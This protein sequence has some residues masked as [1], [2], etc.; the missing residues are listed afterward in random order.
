MS[1]ERRSPRGFSSRSPKRGVSKRFVFGGFMPR[2]PAH[3]PPT[4]RL[5]RLRKRHLGARAATAR[6]LEGLLDGIHESCEL[7]GVKTPGAPQTPLTVLDAAIAFSPP[8]SSGRALGRIEEGAVASGSEGAVPHSASPEGGQAAPQGGLR[9][10][11]VW[12]HQTSDQSVKPCYQYA[13]H[14]AMIHRMILH[15]TCYEPSGI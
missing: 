9:W 4:M 3:T 5:A 14:H 10:H 13:T 1:A 8:P 7:V 12:P 11:F 2:P 15:S 6:S